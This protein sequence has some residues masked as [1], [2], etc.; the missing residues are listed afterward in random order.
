MPIFNVSRRITIS[1]KRFAI[2]VFSCSLII[3]SQAAIATITS[4]LRSKKGMVVSAHPLASDAGITMLRQ[5]GNA[6]DAA[7]AT[8]FA[9]S[10]V[11]PFSAGIGG[12]GFLLMHSGKT[13]EIK[14][15]DFR[16]RAPLK[17][18]KDMYLDADGKVRP[19]AS[20]T[21]YLAVATP[22]TVAGMY[23]VHRLYGKLPWAEVVKPA[24][25]LA[26]DGFILRR[27][28][29]PSYLTVNNTRLQ[30][31]LNNP[32]MREIFTR[33]GEF[34]QPGERLVQRDLAR[35]LTDIA[36]S[37]HS[38]Y[39]G[40]IAWAIA[41]DMAK[42]GGLITLEDLK[43]YKP[44]WRNPVCG[45]FRQAKICS[46][47]PP[48]S[49]GVHLLQM[50][51]IIGETDLQSLGWH[52]PDALHLMVEAMKIA[53]ADRSEFLGDPDF[54][55]VPVEKLISPDYAQ[56]RRLEIDMKRAKPASQI[57]PVDL[58]SFPTPH[59]LLPTPILPKEST[60]TSH[61]TVV[62][63]EHNAVSLTFTINL[64]F[65]AGIATPGTGIVLNNQM[66]DFAAAPG[67]PNAF[68]LV[69]N[70]ANALAQLANGI[71]PRKTPL[72]SMTPTIITE[73]GRL[74]MAVGTPGGSTIITQVLQIIL[75]VLEYQMDVGAAVS[76]PRIHHQWLPDQLRVERWGLDTLTLQ[77]LRRRG[78]KIN[79]SNSWGNANAIAVTA[80][81]DLEAAADPRGQGF[82]RSF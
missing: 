70:E 62:D 9:I 57:K 68:G 75:N 40:N 27:V 52:H 61:L 23:E 81:G 65:G 64:G 78:H 63:D 44:I 13:G 58:P 54:I 26:Q 19:N 41:S 22:G 71:A 51:N 29:S 20:V 43:A 16:E 67:V 79:E 2:A 48:S 35:T 12:G 31:M 80:E 76:V 6:V 8:T 32:G 73:N 56:K 47:P 34:Y 7:V 17:A 38:F 28:L 59:G 74:R 45:K 39:T 55:K 10:V 1:T 49:G 30:T 18:T 25:A 14:A 15:L 53:Y 46:M 5:G 66:D 72:S 37:P 69:G 3:Y 24:I 50:L 33:D 77:E 11:E 21:G 60:E 36:R 4:P 82:T 42:N